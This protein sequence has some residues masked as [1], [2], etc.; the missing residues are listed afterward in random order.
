[1][2]IRLELG[3]IL[4]L[5]L[6]LVLTNLNGQST[7]LADANFEEIFLQAQKGDPVAQVRISDF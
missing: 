3:G 6:G 7:N 4:V 5:F 2:K 1:M